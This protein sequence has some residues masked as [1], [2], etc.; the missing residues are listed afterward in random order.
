MAIVEG[1]VIWGSIALAAALLG[2]ILAGIKN[3]DYSF[4]IAWSFLVPPFVL[5]LLFL[6]RQEGPRPRRPT[7]DEQERRQRW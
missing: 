7:L 3:R 4:W 2:G 5:L 1:I 6:P